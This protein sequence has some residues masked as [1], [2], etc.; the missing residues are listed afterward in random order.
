[1]RFHD[2]IE[3]TKNKFA[4]Q[5]N[6]LASC[7]YVFAEKDPEGECSRI[8][9]V[10][11]SNQQIVHAL[12]P[13]LDK[14]DETELA[15]LQEC[16]IEAVMVE[17]VLQKLSQN[18]HQRLYDVFMKTGIDLPNLVSSFNRVERLTNPVFAEGI[19]PPSAAIKLCQFDDIGEDITVRAMNGDFD[20][21]APRQYILNQVVSILGQRYNPNPIMIG[22][23]GVGKSQIVHVLAR[24]VTRGEVPS[25]DPK[26][27]FI[28]VSVAQITAGTQ[29]RG[30]FESKIVNLINKV[31]SSK[32]SVI[33]FFDEIH[34]LCG[35]GNTHGNQ[36]TAENIL[37]PH[38]ADGRIKIIGATTTSEYKRYIEL[39]DPALARRFSPVLVEE[40]VSRELEEIILSQAKELSA[41]HKVA[42]SDNLILSAISL[43]D[44]V[45]ANRRQPS[46][47]VDLLDLALSQA[48]SE[49]KSELT[50]ER[51][52]ATLSPSEQATLRLNKKQD[53]LLTLNTELKAKVI[54]QNEAIDDYTSSLMLSFLGL[55]DLQK[56]RGTYI[57]IGPSGVGKTELANQTAI[58]LFGDPTAIIRLDMNEYSNQASTTQLIGSSHG[59]V[60]YED[61]TYFIREIRRISEGVLL[62]DEIEKAHSSVWNIL[63]RILEEGTI[64]TA[65]GEKIS[66]RNFTVIMTSNAVKASDLSAHSI[67]FSAVAQKLNIDNLLSERFSP[68]FINRVEVVLF[69]SLNNDAIR[70]IMKLRLDELLERLC[71][72]RIK[73]QY[74]ETILITHLMS[75]WN[76]SQRNARGVLRHLETH[77]L[78][79]ITNAVIGMVGDKGILVT[80]NENFYRFGRPD[81]EVNSTGTMVA[82]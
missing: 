22:E 20:Y 2:I 69:E 24:E 53:C 52:I 44:Q 9:S 72:N 1:M 67:G 79:P 50:Q 11:A 47:T 34:M 59:F 31:V 30:A 78:I 15:F 55:R 62:L 56:N 25:I 10:Y 81:V 16:I 39:T 61:E 51:L 65:R 77:L 21:L 74:N 63:L 46:K 18:P 75:K 3:L 36:I 43:A 5:M 76:A 7:F 58:Q 32:V 27:Q 12:E 17:D 26:T 40:P 6:N 28:S 45:K 64:H 48:R 35:A 23:A 70:R 33:L 38:L 54:G 57:F 71:Q 4:G 37:K 42:I 14:F 8:F 73:L 80:L 49:R 19:I 41:H 66:T 68:E 13:F 29:Y 60:G 82:V